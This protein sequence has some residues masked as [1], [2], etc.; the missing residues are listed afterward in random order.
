MKEYIAFCLEK[1]LEEE[2]TDSVKS[3]LKERGVI[4]NT[5]STCYIQSSNKDFNMKE[6]KSRLKKIWDY[7]MDENNYGSLEKA[8]MFNQIISREPRIGPRVREESM[9]GLMVALHIITTFLLCFP[10]TLLQVLGHIFYEPFAYANLRA[11]ISKY[12]YILYTYIRNDIMYFP[13]R[14]VTKLFSNQT[15]FIHLFLFAIIL[16]FLVLHLSQIGSRYL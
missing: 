15:E 8:K 14:V 12:Y 4:L 6:L 9:R 2:E 7:R 16:L 11:L 1:L 5:K 13:W 3:T 10:F